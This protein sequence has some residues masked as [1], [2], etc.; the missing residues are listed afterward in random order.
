MGQ[1]GHQAV[2]QKSLEKIGKLEL[3]QLKANKLDGKLILLVLEIVLASLFLRSHCYICKRIVAVLNPNV[4]NPKIIEKV[5]YYTYMTLCFY[6]SSNNTMVQVTFWA[7][8]F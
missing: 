7:V 6:S 1:Q 5:D 3:F 2:V 4:S 8:N